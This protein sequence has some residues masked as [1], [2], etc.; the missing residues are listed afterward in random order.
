MRKIDWCKE[1][2]KG[3]RIQQPSENLS[4]G[5]IL[6]ANTALEAMREVDSFEWKIVTSYYSIYFSL[7]SLLMQLGLKSEIHSCTI[8]F[9]KKFLTDYFSELELTFI[10]D[11]FELRNK[12]QYYL[13][14]TITR[15]KIDEFSQ[16]TLLFHIKCKQVR[17]SQN[18]I[19]SIR[20]QFDHG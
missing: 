13:D 15:D 1:Q 6:K 8:E 5:Y 4:R 17:F 3:F 20:K 10:E 7:Y 14:Y 18:E 2:K 9:A 12:L 11:A 16:K 19:K